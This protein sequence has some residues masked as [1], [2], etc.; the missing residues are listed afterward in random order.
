[1]RSLPADGSVLTVRILF[2]EQHAQ[3]LAASIF[4]RYPALP[5]AAQGLHR[6]AHPRELARYLADGLSE[7]E[8]ARLRL[9][10]GIYK[11]GNTV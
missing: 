7:A 3:P 2:G 10:V 5:Y 11:P 6:E 8:A 1:M 9:Y 4:R